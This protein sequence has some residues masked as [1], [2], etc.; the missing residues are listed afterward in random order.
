M[1]VSTVLETTGKY[2]L[3][4]NLLKYADYYNT[5]ADTT[6]CPKTQQQHFFEHWSQ[7]FLTMTILISTNEVNQLNNIIF[8]FFIH[9]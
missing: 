2:Y 4:N 1:L 3:I 7:F 5:H 6:R 8:I 9:K